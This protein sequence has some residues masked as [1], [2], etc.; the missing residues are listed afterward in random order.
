MQSAGNVSLP[1]QSSHL[2]HVFTQ[3]AD[4][5]HAGHF[6]GSLMSARVQVFV[7]KMFLVPPAGSGM[8]QHPKQS[9]PFGA[10]ALQNF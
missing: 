9:H 2:S 6:V 4:C 3:S 5:V 1:T 10:Y 7:M 8:A